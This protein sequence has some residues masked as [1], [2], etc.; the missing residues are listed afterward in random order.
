MI[1]SFDPV[2]EQAK[3]TARAQEALRA[4]RLRIELV[5]PDQWHVTN[6]DNAP[7]TVT[8]SLDD[9]GWRCTCDDFT[10]KC[11]TY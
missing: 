8:R 7:Y 1:R 6:G 3:R 2:A 11:R 5:Q 10:G 4:E 9:S